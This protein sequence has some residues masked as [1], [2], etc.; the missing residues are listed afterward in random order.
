MGKKLFKLVVLV[1]VLLVAGRWLL[2]WDIRNKVDDAIADLSGVVYITYGRLS[3]GFDGVITVNRIQL[4]SADGEDFSA[5]IQSVEVDMES[6]PALVQQRF[7]R[8]A[9]ESMTIKISGVNANLNHVAAAAE[10]DVDCTH[11]ERQPAPWMLGIDADS[12]ITLKYQYG[13][14]ARDLIVDIDLLVRGAYEFSTQLRFGEVSSNLQRMG[15]LDLIRFNFDD[16]RSMKAWSE[17]CARHHNM[18][19]PAL[20]AAH[21]AGVE[22]YLA[23]RGIGLSEPARAAYA[24]YLDNPE[25]LTLRWLLNISFDEPQAP[26][27]INQR[28]MDRLEVELAGSPISPIFIEVEPLRD[29]PK[30]VAPVQPAAPKGPFE[31]SF[32]EA[33]SYVGKTIHVVTGNKTTT[34]TVLSVGESELVVEVVKDGVNRFSITFYRSRLDK[35]LVDDK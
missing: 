2:Q 29:E 1:A 35:L 28:I 10:V 11:P 3:L 20:H 9:P 4:N 5:F 17:Y 6:L 23:Y 26:E 24:Q 19:V 15:S 31:I 27:V 14:A 32:D 25:R 33:R 7:S 16:I 13:A 30:V 8:A 34:G 18:D 22:K 21:L 12:D